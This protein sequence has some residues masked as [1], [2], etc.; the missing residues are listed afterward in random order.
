MIKI[1]LIFAL[2]VLPFNNVNI[3]HPKT[4]TKNL[5]EWV[6]WDAFSNTFNETADYWQA[7]SAALEAQNLAEE[8]TD[9]DEFLAT[10]KKKEENKTICKL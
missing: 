9:I 1:A 2:G 6:Y 8:R 7:E 4:E 10:V 3:E 5:S